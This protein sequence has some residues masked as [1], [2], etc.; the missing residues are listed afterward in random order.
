MSTVQQQLVRIGA[1]NS[2]MRESSEPTVT[3]GWREWVGLPELGIRRIKAKVD[4]GARTSALHAFDVREV[5]RDGV[6]WV[7]FR[8]HPK[9]RE[10][11]TEI[12]CEAPIVDRR[13]VTDSGGHR[14][15]RHVIRTAVEV[16]EA[17]W[18]IEM[19]LTNRDDML[20]RM[21]LGRSAMRERALV[22]PSRSYLTGRRR[23]RD[24]PS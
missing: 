20:F 9:Q 16:G 12:L 24:R 22:D 1:A 17:R 5:E 10:D 21:L 15:L 2:S 14:E 8:L 6:A 23:R 13:V 11:T 7:V 3:L 19:T 4:T 18:T